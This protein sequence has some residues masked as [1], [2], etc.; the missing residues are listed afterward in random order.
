MSPE[1]EG[2]QFEYIQKAVKIVE[3]LDGETGEVRWQIITSELLGSYDSRMQIKFM[4]GNKIRITGSPH[5][6][7]MGHNIFGG[8]DDIKGCCRYLVK[9]A[10]KRLEIELPS[11]DKWE[12]MRA[13][14]V[15]GFGLD[16]FEQVQEFFKSMRGCVYPRRQA[17]NFG[18]N[19]V[20]FKGAATTLK[21][22]HKGP[23]FK[24]HDM[25]R[26]KKLEG[27]M[28]NP[29]NL[30]LLKDIADRIVRFEVEV[31]KRQM[32]YDQ[33][34]NKCGV[35]ND[36]YFDQVYTREVCKIMR[37]GQSEMEIV[38]DINDVE[39]RIMSFYPGRKGRNLFSIWSRIQLQGEQT[40][41]NNVSRMTWYRYKSDLA[42]CGVSMKGNLKV[43]PG[44][45]IV[46]NKKNLRGFIPLPG[47]HFQVQGIFC[48]IQ[49]AIN[50][51]ELT[52]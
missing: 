34:D 26:L 11:W 49:D 18:V 52:A 30:R 25:P 48:D 47:N 20:Y 45:E 40:V 14:V 36:F 43:L 24:V 19:S 39:E 7:I 8:P 1:I 15:Y 33:V 21:A 38:R 32:K 31:Y 13:D 27:T 41:R 9:L 35:L 23:E 44:L 42:Y 51:L 16:S 50:Q 3:Q 37:E 28:Y 29:Y 6:F 2:L 4:Q 46:N 22:Y 10:S 17:M 5:K 12:L